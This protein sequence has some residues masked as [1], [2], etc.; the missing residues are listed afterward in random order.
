ML[1]SCLDKFDYTYQNA[2]NNRQTYRQMWYFNQNNGKCQ[3]FWFD[4]C[5][6]SKSQ[7]IFETQ[8]FCQNT[9]EIPGTINFILF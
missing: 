3:K 9:C 1:V 6:S 7:N 8:N 2:C 5:I 4:G